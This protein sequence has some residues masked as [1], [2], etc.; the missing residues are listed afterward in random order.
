M[1]LGFADF[2]DG[3][4]VGMIQ[5]GSRARLAQQPRPRP[6]VSESVLRQNLQRHVAV[7]LDVVSSIDFAHAAF[8]NGREDLVVGEL[9]T[10][11]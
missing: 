4:D 3:T 6:L 11:V 2:V 9:V 7:E 5:R 10:G 1:P 8:A